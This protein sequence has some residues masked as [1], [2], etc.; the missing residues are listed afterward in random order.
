MNR[1]LLCASALLSLL[2]AIPALAGEVPTPTRTSASVPQAA[3]SSSYDF[4]T[5]ALLGLLWLY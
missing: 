1:K 5:D 4:F 2:V 3:E